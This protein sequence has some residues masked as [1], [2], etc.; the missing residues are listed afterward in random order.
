[1]PNVT[2]PR[3]E[4]PS[5]SSGSRF[6]AIRPLSRARS[7]AFAVPGENASSI[8]WTVAEN[9]GPSFCCECWHPGVKRVPLASCADADAASPR[10][11]NEST[12]M[13]GAVYAAWVV[14]KKKQ[15]ECGGL[16]LSPG[17]AGKK[18]NLV[19]LVFFGERRGSRRTATRQRRHKRAA[20]DADARTKA[21]STSSRAGTR[22]RTGTP[23]EA[24]Q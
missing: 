5:H 9:E 2:L 4:G 17:K 13:C 1:M 19:F 7:W 12:M 14:Q 10:R 18:Y 21:C 8:A 22:A 6:H 24:L 20:S 3:W 15:G 23:Y 16:F 11:M